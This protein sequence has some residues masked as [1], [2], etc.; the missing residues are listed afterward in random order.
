MNLWEPMGDLGTGEK[1]EHLWLG[2]H[3]SKGQGNQ[4]GVWCYK[5]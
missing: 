2:G 5:S 3:I 4:E 1:K